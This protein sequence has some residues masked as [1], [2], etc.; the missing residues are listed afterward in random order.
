M[1]LEF[2]HDTPLPESFSLR[3]DKNSA[4][5]IDTCNQAYKSRRLLIEAVDGT[6]S[7]NN[8]GVHANGKVL[9][10]IIFFNFFTITYYKNYF[11]IL[12]TTTN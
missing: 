9:F 12:D 2:E 10:L 3:N 8:N 4:F 5:T 6:C 1:C 11:R 7:D